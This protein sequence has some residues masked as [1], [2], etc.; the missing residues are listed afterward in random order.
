MVVVEVRRKACESS[1]CV[2]DDRWN[3]PTV[4]DLGDVVTSTFRWLSRR[5]AK[6]STMPF[7]RL[8]LAVLC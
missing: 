3:V 1:W 5:H 6:F 2:S 8:K 7:K 4:G